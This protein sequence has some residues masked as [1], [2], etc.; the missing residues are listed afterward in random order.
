MSDYLVELGTNANARKIV[1]A[2]GLPLPMP[3][4]LARGQGAWQ[5]RFLEGKEVVVVPSGGKAMT[6]ALADALAIAGA[7][8]SVAGELDDAWTAAAEAW[9]RPVEQVEADG[10][11]ERLHAVVVDA[12]EFE[13]PADLKQLHEAL[14]PRVKA[15]GRNGRIVVLGRPHSPRNKPTQAATR[16]AIEGFVR[17]LSK[18]VGGKG[19]TANLVHVGR[20]SERGAI[21]PLRFF[22]SRR[23]AFIS[24]QVLTAQGG[25]PV[26][27]PAWER[28][29]DGKNALVTGA[30][31]G[32]GAATAA[33]LAREGARVLCLDRPDDAELLAE[34]ARKVGGVPVP[35]DITA[36]DAA[37]QILAA[38]GD[39]ETLDVLVHNAGVTR[40][41]TL[42]RMDDAKWNLTL[43]VN[44]AA[45]LRTT[46]AL[47]DR[48]SDGGRI[49]AL[50][51]VSGIAGNFGQT[52]YSC[53]KA[54][55]I[56]FIEASDA[57]YKNRGITVNGIAPGFIETRMTAAI[58]VAT[59]EAGRRMSALAQ[60]GLPID[61]AEAVTFLATPGAWSVHG[62]LLR[63][64]GGALIGA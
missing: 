55:V 53:S 13:T 36:D 19:I 40:D 6:E 57:A 43:E 39:G 61:I 45:I 24:G 23:S 59:R 27:D 48:M 11:P 21:G 29:L 62:R 46:D 20:G 26:R 3:Q 54:G 12:T 18:E 17:A 33:T 64:C 15:I 25:S 8:V 32:I 28:P 30:A 16:R 38:L 44:L 49:V 9:G 4:K 31:R 56:G 60:G 7:A 41:K 2:L 37:E 42:A 5:T 58:P 63:V 47:I 50:S 51:S 14:Q 10:S 52:N 35:V 22:L 1:K 34:V